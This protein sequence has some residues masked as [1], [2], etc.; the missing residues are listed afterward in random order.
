MTPGSVCAPLMSFRTF[1]T[2]ALSRAA[3]IS[4]TVD[5]PIP[6][7]TRQYNKR[8]CSEVTDPLYLSPLIL[9]TVDHFEGTADPSDAGPESS[10]AIGG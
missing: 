2:G 5:L 6:S 9:G 3:S 1:E 7:F 10:I 8:Q 4:S